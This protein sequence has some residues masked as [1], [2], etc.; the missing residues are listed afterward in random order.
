MKLC[1]R[2]K[3]YYEIE[4]SDDM[5]DS[6]AARDMWMPNVGIWYTYPQFTSR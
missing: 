5:S 1:Q 6:I 3:M 2:F 4:I